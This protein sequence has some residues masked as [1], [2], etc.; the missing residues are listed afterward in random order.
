M[1]KKRKTKLSFKERV[2]EVVR[3]IPE[4]SVL[5]YRQVAKQAGSPDASRA[6]G[7]ILNTNYDPG[8]P[9]HRVVRS[10]GAA[11]GYNRGVKQKIL[12]LRSEGVR[13]L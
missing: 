5:T 7:N 8:I 11:G 12:K 1:K 13:I 6:V 3:A 10:D 9:C 2:F 4:G